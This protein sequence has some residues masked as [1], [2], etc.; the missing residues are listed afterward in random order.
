MNIDFSRQASRDLRSIKAYYA[1]LGDGPYGNVTN[2]IFETFDLLL[3]HPEAG[4]PTA[5]G[6]RKIVSAAYRFVI[7]Y[8]VVGDMVLVEG[9][10]RQQDRSR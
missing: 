1:A 7:V 4:R 9:M 8:R 5:L 2:D 3:C 10:F 6:L